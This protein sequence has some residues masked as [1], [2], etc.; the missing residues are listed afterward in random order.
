MQI[1]ETVELPLNSAERIFMNPKHCLLISQH[2]IYQ[3]KLLTLNYCHSIILAYIVYRF[4][5]IIN[6]CCKQCIC[7]LCE[8]ENTAF[9]SSFNSVTDPLAPDFRSGNGNPS[10]LSVIA[11]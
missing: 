5:L 7:S 2:I 4:I 9:D 3:N 1:T 8:A 10:E 6:S 11:L